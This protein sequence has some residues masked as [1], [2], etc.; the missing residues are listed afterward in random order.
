MQYAAHNVASNDAVSAAWNRRADIAAV[1]PAQVRVKPLDIAYV[2]RHAFLSGV[3]AA[4]NAPSHEP[5]NGPALW[6]DYDPGDNPALS[7]ILA[8]LEPQPDPAAIREAALREAAAKIQ[9]KVIYL[10]DQDRELALSLAIYG[11][12][13]ILALI[14]EKK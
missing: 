13:A 5:I 14:G 6:L 1:Q 9:E 3:V 4:R 8:A 10:K 11:R 2:Q 12:D 7:R